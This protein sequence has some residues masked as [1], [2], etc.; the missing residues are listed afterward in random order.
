MLIVKLKGA[1][2]AILASLT[3]VHEFYLK[4]FDHWFLGIFHLLLSVLD[5]H[6]NCERLAADAV[7]LGGQC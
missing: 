5:V 4:L 3:E 2:K 7:M 1:S 6:K